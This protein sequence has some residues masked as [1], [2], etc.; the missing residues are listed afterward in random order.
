MAHLTTEEILNILGDHPWDKNRLRKAYFSDFQKAYE[1]LENLPG[2]IVF[3]EIKSLRL[4]LDIFVDAINDLISSINNFKFESAHPEFWHK[5]NRSHSDRI[6]VTIQR[7]ILCSAMCA[8]ALVDHSREFS[9]KYPIPGYE[10]EVARVFQNNGRHRFIHSLRR[11]LAH[12]KFTKADWHISHSKEGRKVVFLFP[13][14]TLLEFKDWNSAAKSFI[15]SQPNGVDVEE[16]FYTYSKEVRR[17]HNWFRV[18]IFDQY[19]DNISEYLKYLRCV[20]GFN[21]ESTWKT[22]IHQVIPQRNIDPYMYLDQYLTEDQLE[23]VFALPYRSKEQLD[24]IIELMDSYKICSD[25]MREE[26]YKLCRI[27]EP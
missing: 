20:K 5:A 27:K 14:D 7:G 24:R 8:M 10:D 1:I 23:D 25:S 6:E 17:F 11:F 19:G 16:L 26:V 21:S 13:K 12:I 18:S 22:L 9:K 3:N 2:G 15:N 4:S